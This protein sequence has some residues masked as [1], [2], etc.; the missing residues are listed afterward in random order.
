MAR[1]LQ[2]YYDRIVAVNLT[3]FIIYLL[4]KCISV[5]ILC[6]DVAKQLQKRTLC[7]C[8]C[9]CQSSELCE[10]KSTSSRESLPWLILLA[11]GK[12]V[13]LKDTSKLH[14][15]CIKNYDRIASYCGQITVLYVVIVGSIILALGSALDLTLFSP[16]HICTEDPN[17]DCYPQL[18]SGANA[19]DLTMPV[20]ISQPIPD[21]SYWNSERVSK[22]VTFLCFQ[23]EFNFELFLAITGGLL[24]F[25]FIALNVL[26]GALL[27]VTQCC[28]RGKITATP[29][30]LRVVRYISIAFALVLEIVVALLYIV[31]GVSRVSPDSMNDDTGV[32]FLTMH[33]AEILLACGTLTTLLW[34]PWE[35]YVNEQ[36][37]QNDCQNNTDNPSASNVQS[38]D[39]SVSHAENCGAL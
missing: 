23:R 28:M 5:C 11:F 20:N 1:S 34:L 29:S 13:G 18:I 8:T 16:S 3:V 38:E 14:K 35:E 22:Q 12:Q 10:N 32:I 21:C 36:E 19:T 24:G 27:R 26:I 25:A 30:C 39:S 2:N 37:K 31:L 33:A 7:T 4:L 9:T 17:I 6:C 15:L